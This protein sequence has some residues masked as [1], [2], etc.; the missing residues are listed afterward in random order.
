MSDKENR[1]NKSV[2]NSKIS[3]KDT[4]MESCTLWE[5]K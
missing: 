1:H 2:Q 4:M 3:M 5:V